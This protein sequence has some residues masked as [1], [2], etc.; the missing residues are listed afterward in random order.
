MTEA[1]RRTKITARI[2]DAMKPGE[3][4]G[5][6]DLPGFFVRRQTDARVY[7]VRKHALGKRHFVSIGEHGREGLTERRARDKALLV[8][9]A[10]KQGQDPAA[11]RFA[12]RQMPTLAEFAEDFL[13]KR[14]ATLKTGTIGNYRSLL[15]KHIARRDSL[16]RID[17]NAI[18]SLRLD[19]VSHR[20]VALLHA[21]M[22][23]TPRA[24]NHVLAFLS[25]L[26]SEAQAAGLVPEGQNPTRRIKRFTI[27]ARQRFLTTDELSRLGEALTRAEAD[28]SEDPY[29][30]AAI[31]LL[32][33]TGC[34]RDEILGARWEWVDLEGGLLNLPDSKTG[35]KAIHL[36]QAALHL[37]Q[38]LP[39]VQGNPHIIVGAREG[40]R[41][42]NLR[43]VWVRVRR[44]AGLESTM[45]KNGT[46]QEVRIHDLRHSYASILASS[47]ASLP[48]I[49]KLLG[50][51]N[52]QTTA[53][54]AHLSD[55]PIRRLSNEAGETTIRRMRAQS[56]RQVD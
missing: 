17:R 12:T 33:L 15:H 16:G 32:I 10:I 6:T 47:G 13:T 24:A 45:G 25:S 21:D 53:R 28:G 43:K 44:R 7:F 31:R 23:S 14:T 36:N 19:A 46:V 54:Y 20:H 48:M 8:I 22:K 41:W 35:A 4:V 40:K 52:P 27:A 37:L 42:V 50:H 3:C 11:E 56:T 26:Y 5:D 34:R 49:G 39:R 18:G 9:A 30:I 1:F 29:A 38:C 55:D 2:V 51:K